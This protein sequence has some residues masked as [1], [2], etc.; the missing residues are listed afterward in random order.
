MTPT[1]PVCPDVAGELYHGTVWSRPQAQVYRCPACAMFFIDPPMTAAEEA[2]FYADFNTHVQAR[3][4]AVTTTPEEVH[5]KNRPGVALRHA[6][7]GE[8]FAGSA[9]CLEI[10]ALTGA[11]LELLTDVPYKAA[12]EP[13]APNRDYSARFAQ[14]V[15]ADLADVPAGE[16]FD[17]IC[18]FHVFEHISAPLPF[19]QRCRELLAP[20]GSIIIEV[21]HAADPLLSL[22][23]CTAYK[24][25]YFQPMHPYVDSISALRQVFAQAGLTR[26]EAVCWQRFGL[27]NH[28]HWLQAGKPGGNAEYRALFGETTDRQYRATLEVQQLTDTLFFI[29]GT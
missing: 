8:R 5:A 7:I 17:R 27:D 19:L 20:G 25:F 21:P 16:T 22:Y 26:Q 12:I 10:G 3:G 24:D 2:A 9:R 15:Y 18:A 28:L 29:A 11:F 6:F 23:G 4:V 13:C 14:A 1:C